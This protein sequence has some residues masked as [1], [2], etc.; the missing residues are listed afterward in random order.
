MGLPDTQKECRKCGA[1]GLVQWHR[2]SGDFAPWYYR[3]LYKYYE[4]ELV[5]YDEVVKNVKYST[6]EPRFNLY[7]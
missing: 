4:G 7:K 2:V 6:R 5:Y 3:L 1:H